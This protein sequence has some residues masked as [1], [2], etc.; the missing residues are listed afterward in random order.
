[1]E[2]GCIHGPWNRTTL[3]SLTDPW[4]QENRRNRLSD[5]REF[6]DDDW[7]L[8]TGRS[9]GLLDLHA[10]R[11]NIAGK[12][13]LVTGAGGFIGSAL[14]REL[15]K[16][17]PA[18]L[19]LLDVGELGLHQLDYDLQRAG[20]RLRKRLVVGGV[21][22]SA[23][24]DQIFRQYRPQVVF[25]AAACKHVPLME[26][27]PF[28]AAS[29]NILGTQLIVET[30]VA[31][32]AEQCILLS[33]DKAVDPDSIMGATKRVAELI[34][35]GKCSPTK[36]KALRL[37]N[38]LGSSGSVVPLFLDQISRG[39]PVTVTD[40]RVTRYFLPVREAVQHLLATLAIPLSPAIL[41]PDMG[42]AHS[43]CDLARFLIA[44]NSH[45]TTH[46]EITFTGLRP[47][48]KV[49]ERMISTREHLAAPAIK[50]LYKVQTSTIPSA[51]L[52]KCL[53]KIQAAVSKRDLA[54]L[55][56]AI[57]EIVPEYRPSN[58]L[59]HDLAAAPEVPSA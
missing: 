40:S 4:G 41:V 28:T 23:L 37:G 11:E 38:V 35:L 9:P 19:I 24:I 18:E 17:D 29:T 51:Q 1:M 45:N 14:S 10:V 5:V 47:G 55:L 52:S 20:V 33:T 50:G 15:A 49:A 34:L 13:V 58:L 56:N 44:R 42:E 32:G 3:K 25:H 2:L 36:M 21:R 46:V 31:A 54:P 22:D 26:A 39:G 6:E 59:K 16:A 43:I 57:Q 30:A 7:T 48:D 53:E 27:N 8:F 12:R